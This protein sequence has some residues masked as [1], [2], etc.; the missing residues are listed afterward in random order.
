[1]DNSF[2]H[3]YFDPDIVCFVVVVAGM[4]PFWFIFLIIGDNGMVI[5][6]VRW[7]YPVLA[8]RLT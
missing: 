4:C 2:P 3:I 7:L 5:A 6:L 8:R 1:V